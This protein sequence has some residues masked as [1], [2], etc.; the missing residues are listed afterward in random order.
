MLF[1][2]QQNQLAQKAATEAQRNALAKSRVT[3]LL[4]NPLGTVVW[5][6]DVKSALN[7]ARSQI[8]ADS[9]GYAEVR[10]QVN[11]GLI[12]LA[13]E[14][15][16]AG[17]LDDAERIGQT[18][19]QLDPA[20]AGHAKVLADVASA[21][22]A[23]RQKSLQQQAQALAD[24]R[25][26]LVALS[27]K[28]TLT[29]DW[30]RSVAAAMDT[31]RADK[32]VQTEQAVNALGTAIANEAARLADPQHLPQARVA[33]DFG[34]KYAPK[35]A[36]LLAQS[37][38]LDALQ[39]ELQ[40]KAAQE[41]ADAEVKSRI[42]SMKSAVAAGDVGKASQSL[43]RIKV[44]QPDNPFLQT[45]GPK[46]LAD[47]YL[48]QAEDSFQK[49]RY[50]RAADV[51]GQGLGTLGGNPELRAAKARYDVVAAIMAAGGHPLASADYARLKKQLDGI[52]RTDA[53]E[54]GKLEASMK[55]RGQLDARSLAEQLDK[56]KPA[57]VAPA[58]PTV[59][60][61]PATPVAETPAVVP[62]RLPATTG[63]PGAAPATRPPPVAGPAGPGGP[64]SCANPGLVGKGKFCSD[65]I[66]G[67]R[68]PLLVVVPGIGG[69][70]PYA[71]SRAEIS[72]NEFNQFCR[73]TG[74]CAAVTVADQDLGNAPVSNISL[75]QARAYARWLSDLSGGFTYRLPTDAEWAHAA[76]GGGGWKQAEDSNCVLP[77][78]GGGDGSGAPVSARGRSRNPWGL[79]NMTGNV[80]EWVV[81]GGS[82]MVRGGSYS[83]YWSDCSVD[84]KRSDGGSPQ[85]DVGFRVLR[86]L[87]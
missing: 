69:G 54:L 65:A 1:R 77:S 27:S 66:A 32:S 63:K 20:E 6:Q 76:K 46:L 8:G 14:R 40:A 51:L 23:A 86:E 52:R 3:D 68:G 29:P 22:N 44:L 34:L 26:A 10:G 87:K 74:K 42:E 4:A 82:V 31:L 35:S 60:A 64:D 75:D 67:S 48:G 25:T 71:M 30:Q 19:Q 55:M 16:A 47:A 53:T 11:A 17:D 38:A 37:A 73:A 2:S 39:Q 78:A 41:S 58:E 5:L 9:P 83:S 49:G 84:T 45:E 28:P 12:K 72:I 81:S 80:W 24:A 13:R 43:A 59:E 33:V 79:V 85:R 62:G 57:S 70:K 61:P 18:G 15:M 21:R 50:Q 36:P 7:N 56:L